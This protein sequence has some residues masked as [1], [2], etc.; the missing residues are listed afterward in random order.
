MYRIQTETHF[1]AAHFLAGYQGKCSNLHGHRWRVVVQISREN[2]RLDPQDTGMVEDFST[3]KEALEEISA[4]YDHSLIYEKNSMKDTTVS[5]LKGEG[6][7]LREV[8]FRPTAENFAKDF[9]DRLTALR[10]PVSAVEVYETPNNCAIY[11]A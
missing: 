10:F 9:F 1:D 7:L 11:E 3:V 8:K 2:L 5:A 4:Y 6:F